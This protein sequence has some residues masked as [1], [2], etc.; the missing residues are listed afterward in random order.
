MVNR[1]LRL[2]GPIDLHVIA[3]EPAPTGDRP[4]RAALGPAPLAFAAAPRRQ[5]AGWVLAL[6]GVA[7]LTLVLANL[8][9]PRRPPDGAAAVPGAGRDHRRVGGRAP[10]LVAAVARVAGGQLVLHPAL[11]PVHHRRRRELR[12]PARVFLGVRRRSSP[13]SSSSSATAG[14]RRQP[15]PGRGPDPGRA[16]RHD[17]GGRPA[18]A[19]SSTPSRRP[20]ASTASPCCARDGT[21]AGGS[22]PSA[23]SPVPADPA[24]ASLVEPLARR[25]RAGPRRATRSPPTTATCSTPSP[26]SWP[27]CST[28]AGSGPRPAGPTLLAEANE[29]RSALLQA[30]SHDLRTPLASIKAAAS[31]PA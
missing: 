18:A 22:R 20:S 21:G 25:R 12:R 6:A 15:G 28:A 29:L 31:Q 13:T 27:P 2:S 14:R 17:P 10:A 30:V 1:V 19:R 7:L 23:G 26:P 3:H 9:G 16:G 4:A 11:L 8:P 24:D 5:L